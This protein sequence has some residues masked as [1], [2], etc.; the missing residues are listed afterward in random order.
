MKKIIFL[1]AAVMLFTLNG[2]DLS[3]V[4]KTG[5]ADFDFHLRDVNI[6]ARADMKLFRAE[7][8]FEYKVEDQ[9]I[10]EGL[11]NLKME[12]AELFLALEIAKLMNRDINEVVKVYSLNKKEGWGV[13]TQKMGIKPGSREFIALKRKTQYK[14][15]RYKREK[16]R[17]ESEKT[18]K[19]IK[20]K[21]KSSNK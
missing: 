16:L 20:V 12:P 10:D 8:S 1:A 15:E 2:A 3:F 9:L 5:D 19:G 6:Y 11:I 7:I 17:K 21:D 4:A 13:I 14:K 18:Q